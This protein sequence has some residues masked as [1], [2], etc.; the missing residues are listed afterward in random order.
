MSESKYCSI[1]ITFTTEE[2]IKVS[3]ISDDKEIPVKLQDNKEEY[4][5]S[6]AFENNKIII[7]Q[8]NPNSIKFIKDLINNPEEF[9]EYSITYQETQYSVIAEVLLAIIINEFKKKIEKD[10]IIEET[11]LDIPTCDYR[12]I[13]RIKT[14]LRTIGLK[15]FAINSFDYENYS[16]QGEILLEL[17]KKKE[18]YDEFERKIERAKSLIENEE[19]VNGKEKIENVEY[20]QK[21]LSAIKYTTLD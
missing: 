14:S 10:F 1:K 12:V 6:I 20:D 7:C 5:C 8:E 16:E 13:H 4:P 3:V 2:T 9:K 11:L 17:L 19:I 21:N 15:H 18:I